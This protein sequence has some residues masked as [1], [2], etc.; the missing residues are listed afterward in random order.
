MTLS[1]IT[2]AVPLLV[3]AACNNMTLNGPTTF[4]KTPSVAGASIDSV[5]TRVKQEVGLFY[6]DGAKAE[7]N[8]PQLLSDLK[9]TPV[10]GNG[11]IAFDITSVKMDFNV[12]NDQTV[13]GSGGLKIPFGIPSAGGSIGPGLTGSNE[14]VGTIDLVYTYKPLAN[15]PVTNDFDIIRQNAVILPAL[16]SLRDG[17]IK[18]TG[19]RPCFQSLGP[20]DPDQTLTFSVAVTRDTSET[21][22]FNFAILNLSG[23]NENKNTGKNTITVSY[24][25]IP[26]PG[27]VQNLQAIHTKINSR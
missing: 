1:K 23:S 18:A 5:L 20:K 10:C 14:G 24:H 9:V 19:T 7:Q 2:A 26:F 4:D 21:L 3:L 11:H 16:D 6:S 25:P 12:V 8:W 17:L 22:G 13:K 27:G 15:G